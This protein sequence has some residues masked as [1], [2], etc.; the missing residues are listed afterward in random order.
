M[1]S[2]EVDRSASRSE[3]LTSFTRAGYQLT[4]ALTALLT[5][6]VRPRNIHSVRISP[7]SWGMRPLER[8]NKCLLQGRTQ[9]MQC[10]LAPQPNAIQLL[11]SS[12][13]FEMAGEK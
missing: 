2:L 5:Q 9:H 3:M 8:N 13:D 10:F 1:L 6:N 11:Q 7:I 4:S 12:A